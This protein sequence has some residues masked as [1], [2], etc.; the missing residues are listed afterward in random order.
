[1]DQTIYNIS[2]N[3]SDLSVVLQRS[4]SKSSVSVDSGFS[5][6]LEVDTKS[7]L[8]LETRGT[9]VLNTVASKPDSSEIGILNNV[10]PQSQSIQ[11]PST[12][13]NAR[14]SVTNPQQLVADTASGPLSVSTLI[15][16]KRRLELSQQEE[17]NPIKNFKSVFKMFPMAAAVAN[18]EAFVVDILPNTEG[19]ESFTDVQG[20]ALNS[21]ITRA[22][23]SDV[24]MASLRFESSGLDRGRYR[25]ICSDSRTRD[26]VVATVPTLDGLWQ[27]ANI[28]A[29]V[30]GP[31]PNL[32]RATLVMQIPAPEPNDFFN[33]VATQNPTLDTSNW[34]LF[35]RSKTQNGR[36]QWVIGVVDSTIPALRDLNFLPYCGM[37]RVRIVINNANQ[38]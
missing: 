15:N 30:S 10:Q 9:T 4:E 1:M 8:H 13:A 25:L 23:F 32:I 21:S 29:V 27:G 3:L 33:I 12:S 11:Y 22:L 16:P 35:S 37:T 14:V 18:A 24:N 26:W 28:R 5:V 38:N 31:P 20:R 6:Q 36:Q 7:S 17:A 19:V 34:K 2:N